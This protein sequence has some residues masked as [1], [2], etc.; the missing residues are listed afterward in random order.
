MSVVAQR[1]PNRHD[2]Y[3]N[4][5]PGRRNLPLAPP[6]PDPLPHTSP[7]QV[8]APEDEVFISPFEDFDPVNSL[9]VFEES[10]D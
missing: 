1:Y 5:H 9:S 7:P 3:F 10:S 6:V 4:G 2:K 8:P